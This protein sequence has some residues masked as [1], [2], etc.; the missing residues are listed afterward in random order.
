MRGQV[1]RWSG[2]QGTRE[3]EA[4]RRFD[5]FVSSFFVPQA[6]SLKPSACARS[7]AVVNQH[8]GPCASGLSHRHVRSSCAAAPV[9]V[10]GG[11]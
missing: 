4:D 10:G 11:S 1:V 2:G 5:F 3:A 8:H 7:K 9:G 6:Y